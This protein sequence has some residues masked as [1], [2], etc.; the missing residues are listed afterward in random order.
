MGSVAGPNACRFRKPTATILRIGSWHVAESVPAWCYAAREPHVLNSL[1]SGRRL[2]LRIVWLQLA[3][4]LAAGG[5]FLVQGVRDAIAAAAG[6]G[7]VAAGTW[8]LSARVFAGL[9]VGEVALGRW[10]S[11]MI[12]KWVVTLGGMFMILVQFKLPP[13]AAIVGLMAAYAVN[14]LAFRFKG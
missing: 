7:V 10:L 13:L 11:G 9:G 1:D 2:A 5:V 4:A 3:V 12:L 6:A 14:L 8:L